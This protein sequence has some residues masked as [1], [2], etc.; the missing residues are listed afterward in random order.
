MNTSAV[1]SK[2]CAS[3]SQWADVINQNICLRERHESEKPIIPLTTLIEPPTWAVPAKGEA[4]L[5]V[6]VTMYL[7]YNKTNN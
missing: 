7:L 4:R 2:T 1:F 5:E 3:E 6:S